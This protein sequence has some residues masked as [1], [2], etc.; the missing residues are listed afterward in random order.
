MHSGYGAATPTPLIPQPPS[1]K[2]NSYLGQGGGRRGEKEKE[3]CLLSD[4]PFSVFRAPGSFLSYMEEQEE[5]EEGRGERRELLFPSHAIQHSS[6]LCRTGFPLSPPLVDIRVNL[7][8][9][10]KAKSRRTMPWVQGEIGRRRRIWSIPGKKRNWLEFKFCFYFLSNH[11][12]VLIGSENLSCARPSSCLVRKK[13][14]DLF[15]GS[16]KW[17][18]EWCCWVLLLFGEKIFREIVCGTQPKTKE[19][20]HSWLIDL[21]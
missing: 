19:R 7:T 20:K 5:E 4:L 16:G 17:G 11:H 8:G 6:L 12:P 1:P 2:P 15:F 13:K 18:R 10:A 9:A 21:C 14:K 3:G